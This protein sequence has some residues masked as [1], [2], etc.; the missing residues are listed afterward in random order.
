MYFYFG[1]HIK[2]IS[3]KKIILLN[4]ALYAALLLVSSCKKDDSPKSLRD[5]LIGRWNASGRWQAVTDHLTF[6][7]DGTGVDSRDI[8]VPGNMQTYVMGF[9]W[10]LDGADNVSSV[11]TNGPSGYKAFMDG[12]Y[13]LTA[14]NENRMIMADANHATRVDTL[15]KQ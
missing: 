15:I 4:C 11:T 3:M 7:A 2:P 6:N 1:V 8:G 13:H 12:T 14:L 9:S 5:Q 10:T